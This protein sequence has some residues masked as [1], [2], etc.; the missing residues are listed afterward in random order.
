MEPKL[1]WARLALADIYVERKKLTEA[2]TELDAYMVDFKKM[3]NIPEVKKVRDRVA[4][5]LAKTTP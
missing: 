4:A 3:T 5:D 1:R 2:L